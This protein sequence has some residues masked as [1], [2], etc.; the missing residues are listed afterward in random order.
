V[1]VDGERRRAETPAAF[2]PNRH[3]APPPEAS[4][5]D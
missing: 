5:V 1:Q 2:E 4:A 3:V